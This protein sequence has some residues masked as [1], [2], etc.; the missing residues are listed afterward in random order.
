MAIDSRT[1]QVI[2]WLTEERL[3]LKVVAI[4]GGGGLGKTTLDMEVYRKIGEHFQCRAS[5]LV[6]RTLD[7]EKLLRDFRS[8]IDEDAFSKCQSERWE[9]DQIILHI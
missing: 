6:S 9:K 4:V 1:D 5:V 7:P 2:S 3:E 8:Q